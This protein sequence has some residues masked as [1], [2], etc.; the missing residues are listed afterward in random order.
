MKIKFELMSASGSLAG[1]HEKGRKWKRM[2][3]FA[4]HGFLKLKECH[5]SSREKS[6]IGVEESIIVK[7]ALFL[8]RFTL[9]EKLNGKNK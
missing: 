7:S 8:D 6:S 2:A 4:I 5:C 9:K 3:V 1:L